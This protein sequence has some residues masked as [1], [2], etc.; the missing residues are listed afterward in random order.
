ML[1]ELDTQASSSDSQPSNYLPVTTVVPA[2]SF[3][4]RME[5]RACEQPQLERV[6]VRVSRQEERTLKPDCSSLYVKDQ[7][8][9]Q[10]PSAGSDCHH[11]LSV[12]WRRYGP[13]LLHRD[14]ATGNDADISDCELDASLNT[15]P[16]HL[17]CHQATTMICS[18]R[19]GPDVCI[20]QVNATTQITLG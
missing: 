20:L 2:T 13:H 17:R 14:A 1:H 11:D 16:S 18:R 5:V 7:Q 9:R 8:N 6:T 19:P 12:T 4:M 3:E 15:G 10:D